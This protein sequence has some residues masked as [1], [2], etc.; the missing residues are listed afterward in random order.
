M[1][2]SVLT[3]IGDVRLIFLHNAHDLPADFAA[4]NA[5]AAPCMMLIRN[6]PV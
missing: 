4:C 5:R 3:L 1:L 6:R 2:R